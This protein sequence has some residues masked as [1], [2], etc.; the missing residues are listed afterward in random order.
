MRERGLDALTMRSVAEALDAT[1]MAIYHHVR[2]RDDLVRLVV[3]R[4]LAGIEL[5]D[6]SL[7]PVA[8]LRETAHRVRRAGLAYGGVMDVLLDEGPAVPSALRILETTASKL[9]AAGMGW[10]DA[11]DVH[12][13]FFSWLAATIRREDRWRKKDADE[14]GQRAFLVLA[15]TLA[16]DE[17]PALRHVLPRLRE[18]D[19]DVVFTSALE[20]FLSAVEGRLERVASARR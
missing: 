18:T 12:N 20:L 15:E 16:A 19:L 14:P 7:A 3:E 4:V 8:W 11:T 9:H 17:L 2:G 13:A 6:E 1:P 5:P 10:D